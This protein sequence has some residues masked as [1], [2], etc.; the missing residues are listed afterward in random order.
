MLLVLTN[1]TTDR[2]ASKRIEFESSVY[3]VL[4]DKTTGEKL[5]RYTIGFD[6]DN[7]ESEYIDQINPA[8]NLLDCDFVEPEDFYDGWSNDMHVYA[9]SEF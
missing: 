4:T 6:D 5:F 8:I 1:E 3:Y 7:C 2:F 9:K